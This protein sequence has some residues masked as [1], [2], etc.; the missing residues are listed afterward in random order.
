MQQYVSVYMT[1]YVAVYVEAGH[2]ASTSEPYNGDG[3]C[4]CDGDGHQQFEVVWYMY[5]CIIIIISTS[6][7]YT[8][9][10]QI[11]THKLI[12]HGSLTYSR[13]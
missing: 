1:M 5:I 9:Y 3:D 13:L 4:D 8:L 11:N 6:L 12:A 7:L 10:A 2:Q